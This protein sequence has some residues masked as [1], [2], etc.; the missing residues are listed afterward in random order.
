MFLLIIGFVFVGDNV[1]PVIEKQQCN[2]VKSIVYTKPPITKTYYRIIL[3]KELQDYIQ[4]ICQKYDVDTEIMLAIIKTESNFRHDLSSANQ[5][6]AGRSIGIC[7]LNEN[8]LDWYSVL[9]GIKDF[10]INDIKDNIEGGIAV[11]KYYRDYWKERGYNGEELEIYALNSYNM[12]IQGFTRYV[13]KY[14]NISRSYD[15]K[16]LK[17][18]EEL[19]CAKTIIIKD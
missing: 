3:E 2:S 17:Y 1:N 13:S 8:Y 7:Q 19:K 15:K 9:T 6:E 5:S 11:Y 12:G 16:V 14:K 10:N 4:E 18:K